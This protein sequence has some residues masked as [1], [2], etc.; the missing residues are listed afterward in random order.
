[1]PQIA[2]QRFFSTSFISSTKLI[3][4]QPVYINPNS[5]DPVHLI[6][7][8]SF[9]FNSSKEEYIGNSKL[10]KQVW[11][12]GRDFPDLVLFIIERGGERCAAPPTGRI[13]LPVTNVKNSVMSSDDIC[14]RDCCNHCV[15][16]GEALL[17]ILPIISSISCLI[18]PQTMSCNIGGVNR[19]RS[20][21]E[22][23]SCTPSKRNCSGRCFPR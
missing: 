5:N 21:R 4:L 8:N 20:S 9:S 16:C 18:T 22:Q 17:T 23:T 6:A 13:P 11:E 7:N 19:E 14:R 12:I 1:V 3:R 15:N 10:L 2:I